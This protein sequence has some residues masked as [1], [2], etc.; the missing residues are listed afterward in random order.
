M[1]CKIQHF[2]ELP[3][4]IGRQPAV[5]PDVLAVRLT[6]DLLHDGGFEIS[7]RCIIKVEFFWRV[8]FY[9]RTIPPPP[10]ESGERDGVQLSPDCILLLAHAG[11][12]D[13]PKLS[14]KSLIFVML[15]GT[16][17]L[18]GRRTVRFFTPFRMTK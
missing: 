7:V 3:K 17:H 10:D 6:P 4:L 11:F 12:L 9:K 14:Q 2:E 13:A 8:I 5:L 15:S 16:K 1:K 18:Y